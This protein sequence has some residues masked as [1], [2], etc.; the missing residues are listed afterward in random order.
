MSL[1][2]FY[3]NVHVKGVWELRLTHVIE[4]LILTWFKKYAVL[5]ELIFFVI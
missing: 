1:E 3:V 5:C 4:D 2:N